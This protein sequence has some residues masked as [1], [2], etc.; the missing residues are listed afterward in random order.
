MAKFK[1]RD[2]AHAN[3]RATEPSALGK[4]SIEPS[5][6]PLAYD[7]HTPLEELT[8]DHL[9]FSASWIDVL[10]QLIQRSVQ[11]ER[12]LNELKTKGEANATQG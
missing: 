9:R 5:A 11:M 7:L 10:H 3:Y 8:K 12:E 6:V 1:V 2:Q 4:S